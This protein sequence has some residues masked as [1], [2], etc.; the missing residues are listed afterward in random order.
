MLRE[1]AVSSYLTLYNI[2]FYSSASYPLISLTA[3]LVFYAAEALYF[4]LQRP[5]RAPNLKDKLYNTL[6]LHPRWDRR[7]LEDM[8][9]EVFEGFERDRED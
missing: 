9:S 5:L 4:R 6:K 1:K 7:V 2:I 8:L 3:V